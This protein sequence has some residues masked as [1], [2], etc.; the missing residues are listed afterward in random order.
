MEECKNLRI[1]L[2]RKNLSNAVQRIKKYSTLTWTEI[3]AK[4][5]C[6]RF[7]YFGLAIIFYLLENR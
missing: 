6:F 1:Y 7:F 5:L 2:N 4:E 3:R